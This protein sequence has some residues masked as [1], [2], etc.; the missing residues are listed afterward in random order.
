MERIGELSLKS[1]RARGMLHTFSGSFWVAGRMDFL[2]FLFSSPLAE[3]GDKK[4][5]SC[6]EKDFT[7]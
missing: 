6:L 5:F 3:V 2:G 1:E 4:V 7:L